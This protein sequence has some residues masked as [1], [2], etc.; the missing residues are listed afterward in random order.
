M[1]FSIGYTVII[2]TRWALGIEQIVAPHLPVPALLRMVRMAARRDVQLYGAIVK[3]LH[4][5]ATRFLHHFVLKFC[6]ATIFFFVFT[7]TVLGESG[8]K[9]P[10]GQNGPFLFSGNLT[11]LKSYYC[12][13]KLVFNV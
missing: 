5:I 10:T 2:I 3:R 13:S 6:R 9:R 12:T 4:T 8:V 7:L 1:Q 11:H